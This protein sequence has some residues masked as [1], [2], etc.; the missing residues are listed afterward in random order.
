MKDNKKKWV[1]SQLQ[2]VTSMRIDE[3]HTWVNIF[4]TSLTTTAILIV[5][6]FTAAKFP[7]KVPVIIICF[8]GCSIS[9]VL[10]YIQ[11]R[12][13]K[14]MKAQEKTIKEIEDEL[15]LHNSTKNIPRGSLVGA[16]RLMTIVG[17]LQIFGWPIGLIYFLCLC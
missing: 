5:A 8:F 10:L 7:T 14:A 15:G 11:D 1:K 9:G 6:L 3:H 2:N 16:R 4:L 12:A 13:L 17:F